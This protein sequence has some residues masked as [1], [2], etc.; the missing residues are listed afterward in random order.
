MLRDAGVVSRA[1]GRLDGGPDTPLDDVDVL[2]AGERDLVLRGWNDTAVAVP[3]GTV[4]ELFA[5]RVA[6]APDAVAVRG[7]WCVAVVCGV[8]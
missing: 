8:G 4:V 6:A 2:D 7:R 1:G 3:D 5:R